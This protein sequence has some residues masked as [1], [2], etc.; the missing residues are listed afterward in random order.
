[1]NILF[2]RKCNHNRRCSQFAPISFV[3]S[4]QRVEGFFGLHARITYFTQIYLLLPAVSP[5]DAYVASIL[6]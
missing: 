4:S 2:E 3:V 5:T 1:M 6:K